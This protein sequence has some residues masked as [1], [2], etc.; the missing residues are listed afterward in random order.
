MR[1]VVIVS[2]NH[3]FQFTLYNGGLGPLLFVRLFC[4]KGLSILSAL[5]CLALCGFGCDISAFLSYGQKMLVPLSY[6]EY[7]FAI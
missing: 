3:F 1:E 4:L 5:P 7:L 2:L 6:N